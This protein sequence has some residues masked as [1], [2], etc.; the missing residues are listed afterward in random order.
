MSTTF[1]HPFVYVGTYTEKE[2]SRSNGI[3][4]YRMD[5]ASGE[6]RF[7]GEVKG[8]LNPS[9]LALHPGQ[10]FLYAVNSYEISILLP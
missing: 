1:K 10:N 5:S 3:Y 6:L 4:V 9:Y 8:I 2:G 7:V